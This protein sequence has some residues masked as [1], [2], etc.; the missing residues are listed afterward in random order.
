MIKLFPWEMTR[1]QRVM[2]H[3][4]AKAVQCSDKSIHPGF[5]ETKTPLG[6]HV[7]I[8]KRYTMSTRGD[9]ITL[10]WRHNG[11]DGVSNHQHRHCLINRLFRRRSK[12]TSKLRDTGLCAGNSP[13]NSPHKWPVTRKMFAFDDVIMITCTSHSNT[14]IIASIRMWKLIRNTLALC[15]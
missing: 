13:V 4:L 8:L 2:L 5:T 11:H 14:R 3:Y 6:R 1:F 9:F 7:E 12:K 10:Q 15:I